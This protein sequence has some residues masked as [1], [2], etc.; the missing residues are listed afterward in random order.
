MEKVTRESLAL[1]NTPLEVRDQVS[2]L[3]AICHPAE[4]SYLPA[5]TSGQFLHLKMERAVVLRR[6]SLF[7]SRPAAL[8]T[9]NITSPTVRTFEGKSLS[10]SKRWEDNSHE[11][12]LVS[13]QSDA[14]LSGPMS[15]L[16][17]SRAAGDRTQSAASHYVTPPSPT[18]STRHD[19]SLPSPPIL[20]SPSLFLS[21]HHHHWPRSLFPKDLFLAMSP[22]PGSTSLASGSYTQRKGQTLSGKHMT[23]QEHSDS[24]RG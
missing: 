10:G 14:C 7:L 12:D 8:Y 6:D 1:H 23:L 22:D 18:H 24:P 9:V 15:L 4:T 2:D 20:Q 11:R 16:S 17:V 5:S 21:P 3:K 19:I 13:L